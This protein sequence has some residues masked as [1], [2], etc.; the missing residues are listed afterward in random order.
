LNTLFNT[1][2]FSVFE[3]RDGKEIKEDG[4]D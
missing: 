4:A 3:L 2:R 1:D